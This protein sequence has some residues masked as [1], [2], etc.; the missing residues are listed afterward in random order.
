MKPMNRRSFMKTAAAGAGAALLIGTSKTSWAKANDRIRVC[1]MGI[2]GR[3]QSHLGNFGA[4]DNVEVVTL[5]DVDSRLFESRTKKFFSKPGQKAPKV[6]QDIRKV[7]DD[8]D[9]D[10]ISIATPNHWHSLATI[11][12]CQAGKDV[13]CEKPMTH[14]IFEGRKV[15]EAAEKYKK[16]VQHGT[17]LRSN[18]GF[19]EGIRELKNG[20]IGDVYMARCVCY[21]WRPDIGK[22][23]PGEPPEGLDW[24]TWQGPAQ[25]EPFMLNDKGEGIY[26]HYF[27]HWVWAYGNGDIGNQGVHQ[28][29]AARWGLGVNVPYRVA[30][31]GGMFLWDDAKEIYNVSSSSYMFKDEDGKDKMM[32]L[33]VRPWCSND[34]AGGRSFG[35][36]FYGSEGYMTFPNY[37]GYKAY[38]GKNNKLVKEANEGTDR[39]H[40]QNF[41]DCVR[42]RDV[43]KVNAPPIDGHYSSALSHYALTGARVNRVLEIDTE[44]EMVKNDDEAN[45][46]LTREYRDPFVVPKTV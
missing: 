17:Q 19:Q 18:P 24:N 29:D 16:I 23:H 4:I 32:T 20:L 30:S 7:L 13:Y 10:V 6:E 45:K 11:W 12:A 22:A 34:E 25:E 36:M 15:V 42:S 21:K 44:N 35:V 39:N 46:M 41:I 40:F 5:C 14:N 3:G 9:V 27:W 28:L 33:E 8:K 26:V 2:N 1:V 38:Q 31:M 37:E 43:G